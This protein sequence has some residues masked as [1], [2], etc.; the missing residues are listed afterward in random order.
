MYSCSKVGPDVVLGGNEMN[1]LK[2]RPLTGL[3][4]ILGFAVAGSSVVLAQETPTKIAVVDVEMVVAESVQGKALQRRLETFQS[5]IQAQLNSMQEEAR[6]IQQRIADGSNTLSPERLSQLEKEFEDAGIAIR[7]FRDDKQREGQKLQD[8]GLR[9]I[10]QVLQPVFEQV[11]DDMGLDL[12]LNRV[13]GVVLLNSDRLDITT[14]MI[15][16]VGATAESP[17]E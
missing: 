12:I 3:S 10:E 16:R 11:L 2:V 6:A 14:L 1:S 13:P 8:E 7:R 17:A 15:E 5:D 4:L 9:E